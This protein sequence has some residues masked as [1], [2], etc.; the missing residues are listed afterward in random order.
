[1]QKFSTPNLQLHPVSPGLLVIVIFFAAGICWAERFA[2]PNI[3]V[4]LSALLLFCSLFII[5]NFK[6]QC[7]PVVSRIILGFLFFHLGLLQ[8]PY[9]QSIPPAISHHIYNLIKDGQTSTVEGI[10]QRSPSIINTAVGSRTRLLVKVKALYHAHAID[11]GPIIQRY[12]KASGL[13]LLTLDGL[14]PGDLNPGDLILVKTSLSRVHTYSTPGSFNYKKHLANQSIFIKGWVQSPHNLIKVHRYNP[15][16][17]KSFFVML[18]YLPERIRNHIAVFLDKTLSQPAR[19]LYKAILIGDKNDVPASVLNNFTKAGCLHILAI[20]GMHMGLLAMVTIGIISWILKRSTWLLMHAHVLKI[21]ASI[22]L[23]PL[24]FYAL[25]AGLNIPVLRALLMAT[26][27]ILAILFDRPG[28]L[29]NHILLAALLIAI[30]KPWAIFSAAFQ[31]SFS[32]VCAIGLIYPLFYR[33]L[34]KEFQTLF[35]VPASTVVSCGHSPASLKRKIPGIIF[36]WVLSAFA[37]TTVAMLGTLPLLLY[38]FNRFSLVAPC[39]NLL[40]EP[41]ICFWSLILGLAAALC[42]PHFPVLASILFTAGGFGLTTAERICAFF[43]ALPYISLWLP[44]PLPVEIV[45]FY[46]FLI[47]T[48]LALHLRDKSRQKLFVL[49]L[50]FFIFSSAA[51]AITF[52]TRKSPGTASVTFLDVGHGSSIF[53][54]LPKNKNIL[55]DGGGSEN[56]WFNIGERVIAPFLWQKRLRRL[57]AVVIT[58]PHADHYNG[59][60]FILTR[61]RPR[62]LWI[63]GSPVYDKEYR[64]LLGL[65][66]QLGIRTKIATPGDI[67]FQSGTTHLVCLHSG[68]EIPHLLHK[69]DQAYFNNPN[70]RSIVLRLETNS[71]SFLFPAD[72]SARM[73]EVLIKNG[74]RLKA[75]VLM[76]PHHGSASMAVPHHRAGNSSTLLLRRI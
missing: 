56:D 18:P 44:T 6:I 31:L 35:S 38:H 62:E 15:S 64:E 65:A 20:S 10:L 73:A 4:L 29:I 54:Q 27:F 71:R 74:I 50:S 66:H 37:L 40:V 33:F 7:K 63:N 25:I 59:L 48:V 70:D 53:L 5:H 47:S 23:L 32:A 24:L 39:S 41:L 3:Y 1:M 19:G 8:F 28:N 52:I 61:F 2:L 68:G 67:L 12:N 57:D 22:G 43:S 36:K 69:S 60:P 55:I 51:I 13:V 58:H 42:I 26:V 49:A 11:R 46:L 9:Q 72:I 45:I 34:S 76:A 14:L 75:D 30:F 17:P 21:A 16:F